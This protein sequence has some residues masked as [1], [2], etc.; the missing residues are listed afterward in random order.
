MIFFFLMFGNSLL[1]MLQMVEAGAEAAL[2]RARKTRRMGPC[3]PPPPTSLL[4]LADEA[5][6]SWPRFSGESS[7]RLFSQSSANKA[8]STCR[9]NVAFKTKTI[10][11][12][13]LKS[14][15]SVTGIE[16]PKARSSEW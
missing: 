16:Q 9:E 14:D 11:S 12:G 5:N 2:G 7:F 3:A 1:L 15:K 8:T 6:Q 13:E 10:Y 4:P